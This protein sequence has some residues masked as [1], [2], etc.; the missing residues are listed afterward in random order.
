MRQGIL[1]IYDKDTMYACR[2]MQYLNQDATFFLEARVFT[3]LISLQEYLEETKIEVLLLGETIGVEAIEKD[4]IQHI[5]LLSEHGMVRE[6]SEYPYLYKYQSMEGLVKEIALCCVGTAAMYVQ[7]LVET[8]QSKTL[9]GVFSPFG[10]SG[11]TLFSMALGQALSES[12]RALY[13]GMELVSSFEAEENIRGNLSDILYWVRQRK[14]GCLSG[15]TLMAEKR[16]HLDCIFSPDH[17]EELLDV[18]EEDMEF[19][20]KELCKNTPYEI[21][22]FDIGCWNPT[23]F[24]LLEQMHKIYMPEFLNRNFLRKENCLKKSMKL[25]NRSALYQRIKKVELPFDEQIYRG[26]FDVNKMDKT[27]MGQ[28]VWELIK[29]NSL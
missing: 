15:L 6:G 1:A 7:E 25:T 4:H 24:Y 9:I 3:N 19:F 29:K 26:Q 16:G 21:I 20:I 17:Y 18:T 11:K 28:Y 8:A 14:E 27:K 2:L 10:G 13:I 5:M 23:M 22:I 12:G